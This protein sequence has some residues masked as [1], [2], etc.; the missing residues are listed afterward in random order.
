MRRIFARVLVAITAA[1]VAMLVV[2]FACAVWPVADKYPRD[3]AQ[4]KAGPIEYTL[5]GQGPVVLR[6]TGSMDDCQSSG[7]S[8]ALL[9]AGFSILTPS[10]PGYGKT[11]L[12]AG[13]TASQAAEAM[14]ALMDR[15]GITNADVIAESS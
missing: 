15:L 10:R 2:L 1:V 7:G 14:A 5:L 11:P 12:S 4:T 8:E 3:V 9:A 6:L 13:K